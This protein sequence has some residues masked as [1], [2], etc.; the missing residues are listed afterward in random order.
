V[1]DQAAETDADREL[2]KSVDWGIEFAVL[3]PP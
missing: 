3:L 2:T 1:A